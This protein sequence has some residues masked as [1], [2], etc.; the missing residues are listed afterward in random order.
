MKA[1]DLLTVIPIEKVKAASARADSGKRLAR[2]LDSRTSCCRNQFI[3][4]RS[5]RRMYA[6]GFRD[7]RS[8][9][10]CKKAICV[11]ERRQARR[12]VNVIQNLTHDLASESN[13]AQKLNDNADGRCIWELM[14]R[15]SLSGSFY[16][17]KGSSMLDT[18]SKFFCVFISSQ[19]VGQRR[20]IAL[21]NDHE[22]IDRREKDYQPL[23]L[24]VSCSRLHQPRLPPCN[25]TCRQ[26]CGDRSHSLHP[27]G[28]LGFVPV[29]VN[30]ELHKNGKAEHRPQDQDRLFTHS[31]LQY[32]GVG[33]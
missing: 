9:N 6:S 31:Y 3:Y 22:G 20:K 17:D 8:R 33:V 13:H 15:N 32:L 14:K 2:G 11:S 23:S 7:L 16:F 5:V 24:R 21:E 27:G 4:S 19:Q 18:L 29:K 10:Q 30:A 28:P 12:M 26:N 1:M 25:S